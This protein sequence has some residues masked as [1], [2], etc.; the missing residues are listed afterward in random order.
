MIA[1]LS[2]RICFTWLRSQRFRSTS[3]IAPASLIPD[4]GTVAKLQP[5][6]HYIGMS[7]KPMVPLQYPAWVTQD[8]Q[9]LMFVL[10][11]LIGYVAAHSPLDFKLPAGFLHTSHPK[12]HL[13]DVV[14]HKHS[15]LHASALRVASFWGNVYLR[16]ILTHMSRLLLYL[17]YMFTHVLLYLQ[18]MFAHM[19]LLLVCRSADRSAYS[20]FPHHCSFSSWLLSCHRA[21]MAAMANLQLRCN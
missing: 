18:Y 11:G 16:F 4:N 20:S 21:P 2:M 6:G 10:E 15:D 7:D 1:S 3:M 8:G 19:Y 12:L 9:C 17:Q 13:S 5:S 14:L